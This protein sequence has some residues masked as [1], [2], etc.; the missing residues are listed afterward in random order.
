VSEPLPTRVWL[1]TPEGDSDAIAGML[2]L[3][4]S[5]LVFSRAGT[6]AVRIDAAAVH[7][8]RRHRLTPVLEVRYRRGGREPDGLAFFYFAEPPPLPE[9]GEKADRPPHEMLLPSR[10]HIERSGSLLS[11]RAASRLLKRDIDGWVGAIRGAGRAS[12]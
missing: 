3:E 11:M 2:S 1:Y 10:R 8:V 6:E 12:G 5:E 9:P 7:S 4:G